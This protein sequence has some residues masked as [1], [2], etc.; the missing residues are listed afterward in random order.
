LTAKTGDCGKSKKAPFAFNFELAVIMA[1]LFHIGFDRIIRDSAR[2]TATKMVSRPK[3]TTLNAGGEGTRN[4]VA[5]YVDFFTLKDFA[6]SG[7]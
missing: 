2:A 1:F 4:R 5:T 7:V 3:A 6:S